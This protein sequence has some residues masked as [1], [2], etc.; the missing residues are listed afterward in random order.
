MSIVGMQ[1]EWTLF[2]GQA[3][4]ELTGERKLTQTDY[5]G[6]HDERE[7]QTNLRGHVG[8]RGCSR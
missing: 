7:N 6:G 1:A 5:N 2:Y 3:R 8:C 4:G